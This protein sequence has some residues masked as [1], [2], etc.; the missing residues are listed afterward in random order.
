MTKDKMIASG[1]MTI[2]EAAKFLRLS[3]ST[4]YVLM[5]EGGLCYVKIGGSRR[6]P[7]EAVHALAKSNLIG[8]M[9]L[10]T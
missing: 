3:R 1:M 4:L 2:R 9:P 10:L 7:L 8:E 5:D 6:I